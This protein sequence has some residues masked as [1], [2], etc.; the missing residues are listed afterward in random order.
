[1]TV[2]NNDLFYSRLPVNEIPLSDLLT[3]EHLFYKVPDNWLVVITDVKNSTAAIQQGLHETINLVATG[4]IVAVLNIAYRANLTVPFFFGG[5]G[6]TFIVPPSLL[7]ASLHALLIHKENTQRNHDLTL[8][9]GSVPVAEIYYKGQELKI[10]KFKTSDVFSIPV[11]LGNGLAVAE[12]IVKGEDY[13]FNYTSKNGDGLDLTGM[14]CRWDKIKPPENDHEVV[15]LLVMTRELGKQTLAFKKVIDFLDAIY[16]TPQ[17]RRPIS[18]T[19][20]KLKTTLAKISLEMRTKLGGFKAYYFLRTWLEGLYGYYY[21]RTKKGKNYL[22][23]LVDMSDTL[24]ID[25]RI[26]TVIAGTS[27]QRELLEAALSEIELAGEI[28][29]GLYVSKESVMSC[30]VRSMNDRHIHF[31]DGAEGGYTKAAG[32]I[33]KKISSN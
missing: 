5:D 22:S 9:V 19:K 11:L 3:E 18:V 25:G 27:H 21:F 28:L 7:D 4:S 23:Q 13:V 12:K 32:I 14:E 31:V 10:S 16:G 20:L 15:S 33:K 1:M 6:A 29:Y 30:Y 8:R 17:S 2:I 26:N 24:V